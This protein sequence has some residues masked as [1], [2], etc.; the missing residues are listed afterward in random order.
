LCG[1]RRFNFQESVTIW[2][3]GSLAIYQNF[4]HRKRWMFSG[5]YNW[6]SLA[7]PPGR[8]FETTNSRQIIEV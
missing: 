7:M 8:K 6:L 2:Q 3:I 4:E 5:I 1:V